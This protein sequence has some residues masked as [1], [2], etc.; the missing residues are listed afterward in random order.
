MKIR[1]IWKLK[2]LKKSSPIFYGNEGDIACKIKLGNIYD[3]KVEG[4]RI[5]SKCDWYEKRQKSIKFLLNLKKRHV[6]QNWTKTSV[7]NDGAVKE[8]TKINNK[9][10][11]SFCENPFFKNNSIQP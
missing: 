9:S 10:L 5:R 4:F 1:K 3:K 7:I 11:Y 6:I 8:Q 2:D